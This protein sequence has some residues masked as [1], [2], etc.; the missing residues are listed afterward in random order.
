MWSARRLSGRMYI[1]MVRR[2]H[3]KYNPGVTRD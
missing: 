1:G 2:I 3:Q